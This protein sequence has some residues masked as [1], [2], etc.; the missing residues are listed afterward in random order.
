[1]KIFSGFHGHKGFMGG[2][3]AEIHPPHIF[4]NWDF[5]GVYWFERGQI[6]I[7]W[8]HLGE[9]GTGSNQ[10]SP[11]SVF[12]TRD[13]SNTHDRICFPP[14]PPTYATGQVTPMLRQRQKAKIASVTTVL[15]WSAG[16]L[17]RLQL[18]KLL[19][20]WGFGVRYLTHCG[21]VTKIS[22]F[23][24]VKLGTSASSP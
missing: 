10:S 15:T 24:T 21:R 1:M 12:T 4:S 14:P 7:Y 17:F 18:V 16:V 6:K 2:S 23:N 3:K 19:F 5:L 11:L 22:V 13:V 8:V 9:R 20:R